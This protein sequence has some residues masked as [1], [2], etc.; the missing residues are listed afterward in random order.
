MTIGCIAVGTALLTAATPQSL[1]DRH[2]VVIGST[3]RQ[4]VLTGFL[5]NDAVA[6]LAVVRIDDQGLKHLRIHSFDGAGW[7]ATLDLAL[8]PEAL[9]VDIGNVAG[10][11]RVLTYEPGRVGWVDPTSAVDH[12]L[13]D[14]TSSFEPPRPEEIPHVDVT[15][16]VNGDGRDDLVVPGPDGFRI[17]VQRATGDFADPVAVGVAAD[18]SRILG[19]D[20]YRYDAWSQS[21]IHQMD[22]NLDGLSD[23]VFWTGER[24]EVRLQN[25]SGEFEPAAETF[26]TDVPFDSDDRSSLAAGDLTGRILH[27]IR[28]LNGDGLGDLVLHSITGSQVSRKQ[29]TYTVHAG[30]RLPNGRTGFVAEPGSTLRSDGRI[31]I[32]LDPYDFNRDGQVD[33]MATTI[34]VGDLR[35]SLWKRIKGAMGDDVRLDLEFYRMENGGYRDAAD[36]VRRIALDGAPSHREPGWVPLDVVLRGPTHVRKRTQETWP[37]AFNRTLLV[38]D[39][40]GDGRLDVLLEA[41][42]T[43]LRVFVGV[44]GPELFASRP[45]SIDVE[46]HDAE[47]TWLVDVNRDGKQDVLTHLPF[48]GRDAHGAAEESAGTERQRVTLL[49]AR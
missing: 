14:V 39:V 30:T 25:D 47:Y 27:S 11:D 21:R 4:T 43:D 8:R 28:D 17:F 31:Q 15:R 46:L 24:F 37:R 32:G 33:V 18:L 12:P 20:G 29:S 1:F 7:T 9:F 44:P 42:F 49:I 22:Y 3:A 19:A 10:Q 13:V 16:D 38:G 45:Q 36:T 35:S 34:A 48:S 41:E 6:D 40:T 23:L 26:E 5:T 2:D